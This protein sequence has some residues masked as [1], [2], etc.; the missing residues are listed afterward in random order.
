MNITTASVIGKRDLQEDRFG[1]I[2]R[3]TG[4]LLAVMDGYGG[5][6]VAESIRQCLENV[7]D[8]AKKLGGDEE[9]TLVSTF[10]ALNLLFRSRR[11]GATLSLVWI[12]QEARF[13]YVGILGDSP[14]IIKNPNDTVPWISPEHNVRTN[15]RE[16]EA[17][18]RRGG[19]Y[20]AGYLHGKTGDWGIQISRALGGAVLGEVLDRR[21][22]IFP[23]PIEPG[24]II[25]AVTDGAVDPGHEKA[26]PRI[27]QLLDLVL[28]GGDADA[29]VKDALAHG[30]DDNATAIVC[31]I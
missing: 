4:T 15:L 27:K 25:L 1:V 23:R 17:A 14:V 29:V 3:E 11:A 24:G 9:A 28:G 12:P 8:G 7:F 22:E 18:I 2:Y 21:P 6:G 26:A 31:R 30:T 16:R 13:A 5:A 20:F 19:F 10:R